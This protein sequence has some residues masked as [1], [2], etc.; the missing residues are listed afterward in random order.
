MNRFRAYAVVC[1]ALLMVGL[2]ALPAMAWQILGAE[3]ESPAFQKVNAGEVIDD[4]LMM[5]GSDIEMD[6]TVQGDLLVFGQNV[7]VSGRVEGDLIV[8]SSYAELSGQVAQNLRGA[9]QEFRIGGV[10]GKNFT[11]AANRIS[12]ENTGHVMKNSSLAGESLSVL[13]PIDGRLDGAFNSVI[14]NSA[15]G[16]DTRLSSNYVELGPAARLGGAL[17]YTSSN[18][19]KMDQAAA[20]SGPVQRIEPP[21]QPVRES[22]ADSE[23]SSVLGILFGI[24]AGFIIWLVWWFIAPSSINSLKASLDEKPGVS[25]G[26]GLACL[27]GIP[28]AGIIC[29]FTI[30]G[31]P[32]SILALLFY[33]SVLIV[34]DVVA[35]YYLG[36]LAANISKQGKL[37]HPVIQA[38]TGIAIIQILAAIPFVGFLVSAAAVSLAFGAIILALYN[39]RHEAM[40][41]ECQAGEAGNGADDSELA[42]IDEKGTAAE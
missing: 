37:A 32:L 31:I 12:I 42:I 8:F 33:I 25:F 13:G 27:F 3:E 9:A 11:A 4:D 34:G 20:V 16:R 1:L 22:R 29:L 35:G 26:L 2:L 19:L 5:L 6:G 7:K 38:L 23:G 15:V 17:Q 39:H 10:I 18:Q 30:V 28:V 24:V 41:G 21:A 40:A 36:G 14:I